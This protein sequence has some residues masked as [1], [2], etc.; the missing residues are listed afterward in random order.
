MEEHFSLHVCQRLIRDCLIPKACAAL[1]PDHRAVAAFSLK[2]SA[3]L[4]ESLAV[5]EDYCPD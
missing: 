2:Q 1:S 5:S 4:A 3:T